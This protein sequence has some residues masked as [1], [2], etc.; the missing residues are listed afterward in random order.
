MTYTLFGY[1]AVPALYVLHIKKTVRVY[2]AI[3]Y[4]LIQVL[5]RE[6]QPEII[7]SDFEQALLNAVKSVFGFHYQTKSIGCQFHFYQANQKW[8]NSNQSHVDLAII[9]KNG[10][11]LPPTPSPVPSSSLREDNLQLL[12][13]PD[14]S[15]SSSSSSSSSSS[16]SGFD[17]GTTSSST[18]TSTTEQS[19]KMPTAPLEFLD[20]SDSDSSDSDTEICTPVSAAGG[21]SAKTKGK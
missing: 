21:R 16:A 4:G 6:F 17:S 19:W 10:V 20:D 1:I 18:S 3:F 8:L 9:E 7:V 12:S 2:E 11:L 14:P 13:P 5:G 15:G